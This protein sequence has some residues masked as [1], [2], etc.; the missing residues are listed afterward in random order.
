MA[1][2]SITS[3]WQLAV[4]VHAYL[5]SR[6]QRWPRRNC[7]KPTLVQTRTVP[8][9]RNWLMNRGCYTRRVFPT[10][11]WSLSKWWPSDRNCSWLANYQIWDVTSLPATLGPRACTFLQLVKSMSYKAVVILTLKWQ[12]VQ[13]TYPLNSHTGV[14]CPPFIS[15]I[16]TVLSDEHVANFVP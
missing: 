16:L 3:L 7:H 10:F 12:M 6:W 5:N 11:R 9:I 4:Q 2:T 14:C 15:N 8:N 13:F 1:N